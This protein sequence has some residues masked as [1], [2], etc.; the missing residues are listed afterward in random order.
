MPETWP[1]GLPKG[2]QLGTPLDIESG[3]VR[4]SMLSGHA[5][6]RVEI[7]LPFDRFQAQL[8][9]SDLELRVF[10]YF[11]RDVLTQVDWYEGPYHDGGGIQTG[12]LRVVA[13]AWQ[14][15]QDPATG[16]WNVSAHIEIANR[17]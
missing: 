7:S 8:V 17:K 6:Q 5:R 13:G 15:S 2:W 3:V 12:T 9:L 14:A 16:A 1:P 4:T 10:E 11:M